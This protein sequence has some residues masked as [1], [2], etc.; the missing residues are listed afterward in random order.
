MVDLRLKFGMGEIEWSDEICIIVV[1]VEKSII[2]GMIVDR[3]SEVL[4]IHSEDIV[5]APDFEI[6]VNTNYILGVC[7]AGGGIKILLNIDKVLLD[8]KIVDIH[9]TDVDNLK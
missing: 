2:L 4:N 3:V 8:K 9:A 5:D 1:Q 7:K 6:D